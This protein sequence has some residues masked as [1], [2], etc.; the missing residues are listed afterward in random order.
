MSYEGP[1]HISFPAYK[2]DYKR[3]KKC[4]QLATT[5]NVFFIRD[6]KRLWVECWSPSFIGCVGLQHP[7]YKLEVY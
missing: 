4:L 1:A 7:A 2:L 5:T 3:C 6:Y